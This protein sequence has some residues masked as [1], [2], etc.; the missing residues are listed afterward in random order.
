MSGKETLLGR[1][2][3]RLETSVISARDEMVV[4]LGALLSGDAEI[5]G[6][7]A[8]ALA[9]A[10]A[11]GA[12]VLPGFALTTAFVGSL[13]K[14]GGFENLPGSILEEVRDAWRL[15]SHGGSRPLIVRSSSTIE[16]GA[17]SSMAGMFSSVLDVKTWDAFIA[18]VSEV[19]NSARVID[20]QDAEGSA[21]MGILVQPLLDAGR[22]GVMFGVDPVS[23]ER[24]RIVIVAV[25]GG[26]D[27]LVA[28]EVEGQTFVLNRRGALISKTGQGSL[29]DRR[30]RKALAHMARANARRFGGP[31]DIEWA[32]D[33][34]G[35]LY[36]FQARP[37]TAVSTQGS[38]PILGPGPV[39]ETFPAPLTRLEIDLWLQP[40][41]E[42]IA[43]ALRIAGAASIRQIERSPVVTAVGGR[44]AVDLEL[45]GISPVRRSIWARLDPIPPARRMAAAW[46]VGRLR[47][48]LPALANS[49]VAKVDAD[50]GR[51]PPL[52]ELTDE[53]LLIILER[54]RPT[55]VSLHGFEVLAGLLETEREDQATGAALALRALALGRSEGFSSEHTIADHPEVLALTPPSISR[56]PQLPDLTRMTLECDAPDP[57]LGPREALRLR[58]RWV[59]ELAARTAR[60]LGL[61]LRAAG[62]IKIPTDIAHLGME[63]LRALPTGGDAPD[64]LADRAA[65]PGPPLPAAFR[66]AADGTPVPVA[67]SGSG[68][69]AA[70]AG[71]G[72]G[73]GKVH[74]GREPHHGDVLVVRT[75]DPDLAPLLPLLGGLVAETGSVLS[76]LAILAREF[77]V[78]T[79]VGCSDALARFP[80]GTALI[81]DGST[82]EVT[83]ADPT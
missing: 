67:S 16:D 52:F 56:P 24:D 63:E 9:K 55:L 38:G 45:F 14:A 1:D 68:S 39:A 79:V 17:A 54:T 32:I 31:Q 83:E 29:L 65:A 81:V 77:R 26:P 42:G 69:G 21:P 22:G 34:A 28:G 59:Q 53:Q 7:K 73:M 57:C 80:E 50:L 47:A 44:A 11:S 74:Q 2:E 76:H 72:R 64:D 23:G 18:A 12:E 71:G 49:T 5:V 41:K 4:A 37:I 75:L 10:T 82:G 48:A 40:L 36:L 66:L 51:V 30:E 3:L 60:E 46:R 62:S 43:L 78:P 13:V 27:A 8:A 19:V 70:G 61:R 15:L 33:Q 35:H 20:L 58:I 6:A 25:E